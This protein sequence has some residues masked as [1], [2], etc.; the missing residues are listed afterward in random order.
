MR[1]L[2]ITTCLCFS[3]FLTSTC[4]AKEFPYREKYPE[5]NILELTNLK[6]AYDSGDF[7]FVDVRSKTEYDAIHIKTAI[8]IPYA[9]A[10]FTGELSK[11]AAEN[12]NKK[13]VV[14]GN[15]L[16]C[17]K[18]YKAAEDATYAMI[19]NVFA[20]D[21][22]IVAWAI[23]YPTD[24]MLLGVELVSTEKQLIS[25]KQFIKRNLDFDTFKEK[26]ASNNVMVIDARDPIQHKQELPGLEKALHVS[27]DKLVQ[28]IVNK[29]R[30]KD[31]QLLVFDQV[32]RQVNWLMYYLVDKGYTDFYFL[33]GGAT[34]V[35]KTQDYRVT[36]TE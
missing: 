34:A 16:D 27:L 2:L 7:I 30:L 13:V 4:I 3:F 15:G 8:N 6:A 35:L 20:Y 5:I 19:P 33:K 28:N 10:R 23:S 14:Y 26:S 25:A 31:K 21:A 29:E 1:Y 17:L 12:S 36:Y 22:G 9:N 11:A 18:S 32:G 24:T